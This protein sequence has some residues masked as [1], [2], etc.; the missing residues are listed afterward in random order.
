MGFGLFVQPV[1]LTG[2]A[3]CGHQ[4]RKDIGEGGGVKKSNLLQI[5]QL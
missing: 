1:T 5:V 2:P 3:I 4:H